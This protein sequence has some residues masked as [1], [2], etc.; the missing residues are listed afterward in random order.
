MIFIYTP[1]PISTYAGNRYLNANL[2][3]TA[4]SSRSAGHGDV[5]HFNISRVGIRNVTGQPCES[6]HLRL[7]NLNTW[8]SQKRMKSMNE[9]TDFD[10]VSLNLIWTTDPDLLSPLELSR[11]TG[12]FPTNTSLIRN[13]QE[14]SLVTSGLKAFCA[15][16][17]QDLSLRKKKFTFLSSFF[18][19]RSSLTNCATKKVHQ[20]INSLS[21][22]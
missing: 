5:Q 14:H 3:K 19:F 13:F 9:S 12:E 20:V 21:A 6:W 1:S 17:S 11:K 8:P 7:L 2:L 15:F 22:I 10:R 18:L 16:L 4:A